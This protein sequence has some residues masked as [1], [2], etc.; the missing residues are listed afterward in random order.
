MRTMTLLPVTT[1]RRPAARH[2]S[3]CSIESCRQTHHLNVSQIRALEP[4]LMTL[5]WREAAALSSTSPELPDDNKIIYNIVLVDMPG[6]QCRSLSTIVLACAW[7]RY[8]ASASSCEPESVL[9][10]VPGFDA[11]LAELHRHRLRDGP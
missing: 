3:I 10:A 2:S 4:D 1:S 5:L 8:G 11:L 6:C 9:D 7:Q